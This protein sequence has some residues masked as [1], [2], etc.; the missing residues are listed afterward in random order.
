MSALDTRLFSSIIDPYDRQHA[1]R[2]LW[3]AN[4]VKTTFQVERGAFAI[5]LP[6][7]MLSDFAGDVT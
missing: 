5:F 1:N 7:R 6:G 2:S 4:V 3:R